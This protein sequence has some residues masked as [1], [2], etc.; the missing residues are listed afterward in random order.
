MDTT[1]QPLLLPLLET[2][3]SSQ[4]P[5]TLG[6]TLTAWHDICPDNLSLLHPYYRRICRILVDADEW[7]QT[8]ALDVLLRYARAMLEKPELA[9]SV[10][11]DESKDINGE[12]QEN[13]EKAK[14]L[15]EGEEEQEDD[16]IDQDI[17]LLLFCAKPLLQSRN[18]AVVLG[19]IRLFYYLAPAKHSEIAQP[20][21]V[22]PLLRLVDG[23]VRPEISSLAVEVCQEVAE[24]RPVSF[25]QFIASCVNLTK[26]PWTF[27][28]GSSRVFIRD[29]F[30]G[31]WTPSASK[32]RRY[33]FFVTL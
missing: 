11:P 1:T 8:V 29:F 14:E 27:F 22:Q 7:G 19:T 10:K 3:L 13:A 20:L 9:G 28:S 4:S 25:P 21:L 18:P 6:V 12:V 32:E 2:L 26:T 5:I 31:Q 16:D 15:E 30:Y 24:Q 33:R 23:L 17:Y